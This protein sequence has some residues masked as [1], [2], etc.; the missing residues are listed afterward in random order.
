MTTIGNDEVVSVTMDGDLVEEVTQDGDIVY[1]RPT[2]SHSQTPTVTDTEIAVDW[3]V[4]PKTVSE[5]TL[6]TNYRQSGASGWNVAES[7]SVT[8]AG[9]YTGNITGLDP[10]TTYEI[11]AGIHDQVNSTW[12]RSSP[13]FTETTEPAEVYVDDFSHT[14][15][16]SHYY[17]S[18]EGQASLPT[19]TSS[20]GHQ[21]EAYGL[22]I[23]YDSP[24]ELFSLP[25]SHSAYDSTEQPNMVANYPSVSNGDVVECY[26]QPVDF[27]SSG[28]I[29]FVFAPT[30]Y[31]AQECIR[32][33]LV[34]DGYIRIEEATGGSWNYYGDPAEDNFSWVDK[35][36]LHRLVFSF[37][38]WP[39]VDAYIWDIDGGSSTQLTSISTQNASGGYGDRGFGWWF[40]HLVDAEISGLKLIEP[41]DI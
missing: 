27:P 2:V 7:Q 23:P 32:V 30:Q 9:T 29:R 18:D 4:D 19:A 20:A 35:S 34:G 11:H 17:I 25:S 16:G 8:S 14:D 36:H 41:S 37:D 38:R 5:V 10:E 39:D 6:R 28:Q 33:R 21:G 24:N 40:N 26:F 12:I 3:N 1:Q 22:H 31:A 13:T 15:V